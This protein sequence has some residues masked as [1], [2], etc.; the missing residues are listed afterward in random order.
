[1]TKYKH[2]IK[3][4]FIF[5][6]KFLMSHI[7]QFTKEKKMSFYHPADLYTYTVPWI[8][9]WHNFVPQKKWSTQNR[10]DST[11]SPQSILYQISK[12]IIDPM[13]YR[14][15]CQISTQGVSPENVTAK[16][17]ESWGLASIRYVMPTR[18]VCN[19]SARMIIANVTI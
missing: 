2:G 15:I 3:N 1:M 5:P 17:G 6:K 18:R 7:Q 13:S 14:K 8:G 9:L 12:N 10:L 16:R 19:E 4:Y 11:A